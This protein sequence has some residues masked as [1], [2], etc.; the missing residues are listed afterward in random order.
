MTFDVDENI[1]DSTSEG[2]KMKFQPFVLEGET[3]PPGSPGPH[4][5]SLLSSYN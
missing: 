5:D 3:C 1:N 2:M 4:S